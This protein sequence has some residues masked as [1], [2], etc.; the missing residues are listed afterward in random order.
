MRLPIYQ[1]DAFTDILFAGNPAAVVL[2]SEFPDDALMQS[3]AKENNLAETAFLV[4]QGPD[5]GLRWF[6]PTVEVPL[7]GHA[8]L[9]SAAVVLQHVRPQDSQVVFHTLSGALTVRRDQGAYVMDLPVRPVI[10]V[11]DNPLLEKALGTKVAQLWRNDFTHLAVLETE[12][13]VRELQV[14]TAA[15]LASGCEGCIVTAPGSGQFDIVSRFFAPGHGVE[16][17]PV[18]GSAHCALLPYWAPILGKNHLLAFQ[19]SSRGGVL[20]CSL[21]G[22]RVFLKGQA[23]MYMEG[24]IQVG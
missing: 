18:T 15:M 6:T 20:D 3:I 10:R 17:D 12:A 7:C 21:E 2:L 16:E 19:A 1:V 5:F 24:Y 4:P 13:Q 23:V 11:D 9:A 14:D 22:D 8:T